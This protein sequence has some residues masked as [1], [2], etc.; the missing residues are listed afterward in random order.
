MA[1][2]KELKSAIMEILVYEV[3]QNNYG[4]LSMMINPFASRVK[5]NREGILFEGDYITKHGVIVG[6][7]HH[8]Y[9]TRKELKP[10]VEWLKPNN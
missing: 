5:C 10:K 3:D 7:V 1:I 9:S 8:R 4:M 2:T 6:K